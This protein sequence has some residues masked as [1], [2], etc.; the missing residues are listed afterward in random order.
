MV[1]G[2]GTTSS[3]PLRVLAWLSRSR[4]RVGTSTPQSRSGT[5]CSTASI[6]K[7]SGS[8]RCQLH[9]GLGWI[10]SLPRGVDICARAQE[11]SEYLVTR[12]GWG[13][14]G[15]S[16]V[17]P[18]PYESVIYPVEAGTVWFYSGLLAAQNPHIIW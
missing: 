2:A 13:V 4:P 14:H 12:W 9:E 6:G 7:Y 17:F 3:S 10:R 16:A 11:Q 8:L 18:L 1:S 15:A 5:R